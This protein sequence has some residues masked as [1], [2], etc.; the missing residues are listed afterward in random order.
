VAV[1]SRTLALGT[2]GIIAGLIAIVTVRAVSD[3]AAAEP[4]AAASASTFHPALPS[5]SAI[6]PT[7]SAN[8]AAP[9]SASARPIDAGPRAAADG[10]GASKQAYDGDLQEHEGGSKLGPKVR[11]MDLEIFDYIANVNKSK[12]GMI[13]DIFP[14]KPYRVKVLLVEDGFVE[15]VWIDL[16]RNGKFDEQWD[17]APDE[18][19]RHLSTKD[20]GRYLVDFRLRNGHW[21]PY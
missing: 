3:G 1:S 17:L 18:V 7:P 6:A 14:K 5:N 9:S 16:N 10:G 13:D 2:A 21:L 19:N 8:T 20:D 4:S 12:R 11:P 15:G